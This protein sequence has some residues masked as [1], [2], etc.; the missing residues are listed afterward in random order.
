MT[1]TSP[2]TRAFR[3]H[4][5]SRAMAALAVLFLT[6]S[7][8][9]AADPG[10]ATPGAT[11][12]ACENLQPPAGSKL[13]FHAYATGEQIYRWN[14][15][16]WSFVGPAAVLFADAAGNGKVG[17]HYSGPTW[18]SVSGSKVVATVLDKCTPDANAIPWLL[19]GVLSNE[20]NGV[21]ER[22]TH[23][24]RVNTVGGNAP[25]AP[26]SAVGD[27]ARVP[28]TAEYLFYRAN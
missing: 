22:A 26:G 15:S 1:K 24:Q 2:A 17:I 25:S 14:G 21:F 3:A 4:T 19:L 23:I 9:A 5:F 12:N 11:L 20:G 13:A 27:E 7:A 8:P 10:S 18:L 28:Y 16:S 6:L